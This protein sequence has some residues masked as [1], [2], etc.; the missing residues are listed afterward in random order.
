MRLSLWLAGKEKGS[1]KIFSS[2]IKFERRVWTW[3]EE[4]EERD[5]TAP[6]LDCFLPLSINIHLFLLSY[7]LTLSPFYLL[8]HITPIPFG[9]FT[10][11]GKEED[12]LIWATHVGTHHHNYHHHK[13]SSLW[14]SSSSCPFIQTVHVHIHHSLLFPPTSIL[15]QIKYLTVKKLLHQLQVYICMWRARFWLI[16]CY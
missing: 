10:A 5:W 7:I 8:H 11:I 16:A 6:K 15:W 14:H 13:C 9:S 4:R 1:S 3:S 2:L 12:G